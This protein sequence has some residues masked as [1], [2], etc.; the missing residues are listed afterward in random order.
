VSDLTDQVILSEVKLTVWDMN[1]FTQWA[2][3]W[4]F[5]WLLTITAAAAV[6]FVQ[7]RF[8]GSGDWK[9]ELAE[10]RSVGSLCFC[11]FLIFC[12]PVFCTAQS[13]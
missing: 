6:W 2:I 12:F 4:R 5:R 1:R 11:T 7:L 10:R 13:L 3:W 9:M 8:F